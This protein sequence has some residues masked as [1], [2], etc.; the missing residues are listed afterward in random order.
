MYEINSKLKKLQDEGRP[1]QVGLIGAG[2]MGTDIVSQIS[3]MVGIDVPVVVDLKTETAVNAYKISGLKEEVI[4]T[5]DLDIAEKALASGKKVATT[6]YKIAIQASQVQVVIDAT[7]SPEM[8]ARVTLECIK[9]KKHIVMMNVECDITVGPIL[10]SMAESSGIVYS[11]T[12]GDE[13]GSIIE[14]YRFA[15]ALGFKVVTAG[16][17]KNNP[18]NIY[19]TPADL[20]EKANA[21]EMSGKMLCEFVDGSKT[22]IEMAAVSNA[23]GLIPD[24]RGMHG[25]KCNVKDLTSIFCRK[26]QGGI[27]EKEGIV[28]YAIGDINPGVFVIVTTDHP[29]II[30]GLVQRDM[31]YGPNYL[32]YRPYHL[33]SIETPI[34]AAQAIIYGES[35]AHPMKKLVA[36]CITI[37]K[38]DL[39][40]GETLDGIGEFSYRASIDTAEVARQANM[41]PVGLAK[42]AKLLGDVKKDEVI[43]YDMVELDNN[44]VLL[45]LRRIQDQMYR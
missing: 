37:A 27:L 28:D 44:S 19:A 9:F 11:L 1:I 3:C 43:T 13:P 6:N 24:I 33:C 4:E 31:G 26:D 42:G 18:L 30:K 7:G 5:D 16:K 15:K 8:G 2:Q 21:R 32:L 12:A 40:A 34:T 39:K 20:Q 14:V 45:Q 10:R 36:E 41:L 22:M 25:P 29:R 23:T 17:G 35:T 38:K